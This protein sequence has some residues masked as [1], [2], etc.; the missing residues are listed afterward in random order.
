[1]AKREYPNVAGKLKTLIH[2]LV[3]ELQAEH[4]DPTLRVLKKVVENSEQKLKDDRDHYETTRQI[5]VEKADELR[6]QIKE[7]ALKEKL[8][9]APE[10]GVTIKFTKGYVKVTYNNKELDRL[11][12]KNPALAE[13][14]NPARSEKE[15]DPR[16]NIVEKVDEPELGSKA[17]PVDAGVQVEG[18]GAE[19]SDGIPF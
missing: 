16:V 6:E 13:M 9:F 10:R 3:F 12:A 17:E 7:Q 2:Q 11:L 14:V 5:Y 19:Q 4:L 15:V 18:V 1:M 8:T